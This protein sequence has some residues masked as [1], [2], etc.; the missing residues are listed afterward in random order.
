MK[1]IKRK[2]GFTL[3]ELLAVI[4]IL[5]I[6]AL[7]TVPTILNIMEKARREAFRDSVLGAFHALDYYLID[8]SLSEIPE[9]GIEVKSLKLNKN[10][11]EYGT[12]IKNEDG[13]LEA[14]SISDG[15]YCANG[16]QENIIIN[17]GECELAIPT[18]KLEIIGEKGVNAWYGESVRVKTITSRAP[19]GGLTFG[20][21]EE[22][23]YEYQV[24]AGKKGEAEIEVETKKEVYCYV[25]TASGIT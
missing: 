6:I 24:G 8:Y 22:E 4:V 3:M 16:E 19:T 12:I 23:N 10:T 14:V 13:K 15:N 25:K 7:I 20:I 9:E 21:G 1:R 17:K 2:N 18:C 11:L 5:A